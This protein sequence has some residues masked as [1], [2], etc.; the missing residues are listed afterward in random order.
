M[1]QAVKHFSWNRWVEGSRMNPAEFAFRCGCTFV[2]GYHQ[3]LVKDWVAPK[4]YQLIGKK[5]EASS[6]SSSRTSHAE[7]FLQPSLNG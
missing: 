5:G 7:T 6:S 1:A 4:S 2:I 3:G